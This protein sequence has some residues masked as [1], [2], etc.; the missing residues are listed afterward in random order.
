MGLIYAGVPKSYVL[1]LKNR[2]AIE[3]FVE[4]GT[5]AGR[6][7]A[8]AAGHFAQVVTIEVSEAQYRGAS[9]RLSQYANVRRLLGDSRALLSELAAS[10]PPSII[11]LDAHS[12]GGTPGLDVE[13]PLLDE[14]RALAP[15]WDRAFVLVDDAR[16]FL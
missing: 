7:A 16:F 11:W 13:C 12:C 8:W 4:T 15:C 3:C 2:F 9:A 5:F 1:S 14:I 6:T 10:L